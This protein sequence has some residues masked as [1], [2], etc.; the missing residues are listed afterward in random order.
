MWHAWSHK[1]KYIVEQTLNLAYTSPKNLPQ[2]CAVQAKL[3]NNN[4]CFGKTLLPLTPRC[5]CWAWCYG[6]EYLWSVGVSS[7][8]C[9]H[10]QPLAHPQPTCWWGR[11]RNREIL[12]GLQALFSNSNNSCAA[13]TVFVTKLKHD[14][15]QA[16]ME[17]IN[18]IPTRLSTARH[19][20]C[21]RHV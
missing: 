7:C 16:F 5:Y 9:I 8:G 18:T 10:S 13:N 6:I 19:Q 14:T 12:D 21:L 3:T 17:K 1:W 20:I 11:V 4:C 15:L 2:H